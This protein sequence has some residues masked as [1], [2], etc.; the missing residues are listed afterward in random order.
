MKIKTS[1]N[2]PPNYEEILKKF[3]VKDMPVVFTYGDTLYNVPENY[4][5]PQ[6][7]ARHE[8]VHMKQQGEDPAGWWKKYIA[9]DQ[10]R[11]EQELEAYAVQYK[12]VK[13]TTSRKR[14]DHFLDVVAFDLSSDVYGRIISFQ[15]A[16]TKIRNLAKQINGATA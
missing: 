9:D 14:S 16:Q 2:K 11:L 5:V 7:L 8:F 13:E 4:N 3:P 15:D 1:T 12:F 6:H 10:F